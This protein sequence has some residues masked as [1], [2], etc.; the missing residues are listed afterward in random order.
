M[1]TQSAIVELRQAIEEQLASL[2]DTNLFGE[3]NDDDKVWMGELVAGLK[4]L[5]VDPSTD[6][7]EEV[8]SWYDGTDSYILQDF[9]PDS[10]EDE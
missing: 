3:S 10:Q 9:L 6:V 2:P 8:A 5:E 1:R 4:K 7:M